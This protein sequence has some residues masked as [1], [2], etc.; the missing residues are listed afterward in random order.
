MAL[1]LIFAPQD[2]LYLLVLRFDNGLL[3][4]AEAMEPG[5][6]NAFRENYIDVLSWRDK[7]SLGLP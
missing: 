1:S 7:E 2:T 4:C 3:S 5:N 6:P